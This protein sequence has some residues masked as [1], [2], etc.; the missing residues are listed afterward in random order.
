MPWSSTCQDN[1]NLELGA[2]VGLDGLD[3]EKDQDF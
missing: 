2:V 3:P 1:P